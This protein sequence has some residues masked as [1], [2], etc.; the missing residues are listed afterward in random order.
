MDCSLFYAQ[1]GQDNIEAGGCI[2]TSV[3][4]LHWK[5]QGTATLPDL[6]FIELVVDLY[7]FRL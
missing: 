2:E 6:R 5:E 7:R 4:L 1:D 3:L